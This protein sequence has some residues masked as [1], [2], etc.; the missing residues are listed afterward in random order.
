M[1]VNKTIRDGAGIK[2]GDTVSVVMERDDAERSVGVP[3]GLKSQDQDCKSQL[4]EALVY[5]SEG[6]CAFNQWSQTGRNSCT[7]AGQSHGDSQD[8]QEMDR[9][10]T[11]D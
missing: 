7:S 1:A 10:D 3:P 6:N 4:R 5:K 9:L 11:P 8:R 2:A